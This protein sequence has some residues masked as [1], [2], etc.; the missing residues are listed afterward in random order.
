MGDRIVKTEDHHPARPFSALLADFCASAP[1][2]VAWQQPDAVLFWAS[3]TFPPHLTSAIDTFM[4][5]SI[6]KTGICYLH[7][8]VVLQHYLVVRGSGHADHTK[9]DISKY[10]Q[11]NITGLE[12]RL[13]TRTD[14]QSHAG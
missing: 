10:V 1:D 5:R 2:R 8:P 9:V 13:V 4:L 7:A 3:P 11:N 14:C 6:Q 12:C